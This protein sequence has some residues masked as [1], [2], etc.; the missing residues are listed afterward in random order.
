MIGFE[1]AGGRGGFGN[2]GDI[3]SAAAWGLDWLELGFAPK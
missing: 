2:G 1:L 3:L